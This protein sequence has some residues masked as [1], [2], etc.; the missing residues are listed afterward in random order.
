[1]QCSTNLFSQDSYQERLRLCFISLKV[2]SQEVS[3]IQADL[4]VEQLLAAAL[5]IQ[6]GLLAQLIAALNINKI[7]CKEIDV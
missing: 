7:V 4:S 3:G 5:D 1:M 6:V 2:G